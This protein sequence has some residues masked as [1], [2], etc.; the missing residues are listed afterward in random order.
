MHLPQIKIC[1]R[2]NKSFECN[3]INIAKCQCS[4]INLSAEE[5]DFLQMNYK[6]CLCLSCLKQI[7]LLNAQK[8]A[9]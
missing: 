6:D 3:A 9:G 5:N 4:T 1:P 8:K 2:C 7:K